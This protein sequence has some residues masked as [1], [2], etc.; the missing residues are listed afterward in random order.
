MHD[1]EIE[2]LGLFPEYAYIIKYVESVHKEF[3]ICGCIEV[4]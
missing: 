2:N 1:R 4:L 3:G